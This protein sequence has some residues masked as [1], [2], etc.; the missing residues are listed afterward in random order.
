MSGAETATLVATLVG[1]LI[2][3]TVSALVFFF[4]TATKA[5]VNTLNAHLQLNADRI[6]QL[7]HENGAYQIE[8]EKLKERVESLKDRV[9]VLEAR[10][11]EL[12]AENR[13]LRK[14]I[15]KEL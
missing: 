10:E 12:L 4:K 13:E 11:A 9:A 14:R 7:E 1:G 8:M 6:R 15:S 3:P 2:V 5:E